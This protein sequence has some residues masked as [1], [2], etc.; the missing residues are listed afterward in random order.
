MKYT[1][2]QFISEPNCFCHLRV[3]PESRD[4]HA[5]VNGPAPEYPPRMSTERDNVSL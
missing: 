1:V 4:T 3:Q 2:I 5:E